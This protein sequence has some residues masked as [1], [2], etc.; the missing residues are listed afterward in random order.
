MLRNFMH[1][2]I[3]HATITE[4][5]LSYVGS[6][7]IDGDI[8]D[9]VGLMENEFVQIVNQNNGERFETYVIEGEH[10]SKVFKVNGPA[11]RKVHI[12]DKLFIIGY[13]QVDLAIEAKPIPKVYDCDLNRMID[14]SKN[15]LY[16]AQS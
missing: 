1:A 6:I 11:A 5:E 12:G 10:G 9:K 15:N 2:K 13:G 4:T 14:T 8:L 3:S 7:T 16:L